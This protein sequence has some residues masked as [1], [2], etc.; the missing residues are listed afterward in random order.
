MKS[1]EHPCDNNPERALLKNTNSWNFSPE[2]VMIWYGDWH[3]PLG[4]STSPLVRSYVWIYCA[5]PGLGVCL[6]CLDVVL[7]TPG[8]P[9]SSPCFPWVLKVLEESICEGFWRDFIWFV[10]WCKMYS[11]FDVLAMT[12]GFLTSSFPMEPWTRMNNRERK[13]LWKSPCIAPMWFQIW[14]MFVRK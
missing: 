5:K 9:L 8:Q 2:R 4:K 13:R 11:N 14:H 12:S 10:I 1:N 6:N 3:L 7:F